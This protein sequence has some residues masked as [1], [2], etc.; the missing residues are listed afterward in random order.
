MEL[1]LHKNTQWAFVDGLLCGILATAMVVK[2]HR[3]ARKNEQLKAELR[4]K[5]SDTIR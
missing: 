5:Y 3:D 2:M 1:N 4:Q